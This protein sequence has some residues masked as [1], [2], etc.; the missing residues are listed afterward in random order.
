MDTSTN[1]QKI[2]L[3]LGNN[4][5]RKVFNAIQDRINRDYDI[6]K[7]IRTL[8]PSIVNQFLIIISTIVLFI[9]ETNFDISSITSSNIAKSIL[10][11]FNT[12]LIAFLSIII[13][14]KS[15]ISFINDFKDIFSASMTTGKYLK[16]QASKYAPKVPTDL[17]KFL[18]GSVVD[19]QILNIAQ[20]LLNNKEIGVIY[21]GLPYC[22][23][24]TT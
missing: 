24:P 15:L 8:K 2:F 16:Y 5:D 3:I 1:K 13:L 23:L 21:S 19:V 11:I 7:L 4:I 18:H 9:S 12:P 17:W 14:M 10:N 20:Q 6:K 22:Q